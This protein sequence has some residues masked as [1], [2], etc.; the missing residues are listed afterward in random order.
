MD[1]LIA[2]IAFTALSL[3]TGALVAAFLVRDPPMRIVC[4]DCEH[5]WYSRYW[6]WERPCPRCGSKRT[7]PETE[8]EARRR[9][10]KRKE[11]PNE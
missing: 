11:N 10:A 4:Y 8:L 9:N 3:A 7:A 1:T 6:A 2:L 5:V